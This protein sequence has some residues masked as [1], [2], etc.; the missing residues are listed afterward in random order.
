MSIDRG[1]QKTIVSIPCVANYGGGPPFCDG[2]TPV[3]RVSLRGG[4]YAGII[5]CGAL[6]RE[7]ESRR[8]GR[9]I[10]LGGVVAELR[11]SEFDSG[12]D[13]LGPEPEANDAMGSTLSDTEEGSGAGT[14]A[15]GD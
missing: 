1:Q 7:G 12:G 4:E 11:R 6:R 8:I 3:G 10:P 2:E 5:I 9:I 14:L 15:A 13:A